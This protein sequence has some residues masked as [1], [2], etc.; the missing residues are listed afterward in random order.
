MNLSQLGSA[1]LLVRAMH[2][3][4][5]ITGSSNRIM[6]FGGGDVDCQLL[7]ETLALE[8]HSRETPREVRP[9]ALVINN[10]SCRSPELGLQAAD[11]VFE[12]RIPSLTFSLNQLLETAGKSLKLS[13]PVS[14]SVRRSFIII[15]FCH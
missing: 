5:F 7:S 2:S 8:G 6:S 10:Y 13:Q 3:L 12:V 9:S 11:H 14:P 15:K 1:S 4:D